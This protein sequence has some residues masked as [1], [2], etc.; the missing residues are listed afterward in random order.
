[1]NID[2]KAAGKMMGSYRRKEKI[3]QKELAKAVG[4]SNNY[5]S[6]IE[7][8]YTVPSLET[9]TELSVALGKT[10]DFFLLGHIRYDIVG[11]YGFSKVSDVIQGGKERY[12]SVYNALQVMDGVDYVMIHDGARPCVNAQMLDRLCESVMT[13]KASV[14]AVPSKDTVRLADDNGYV[15]MTPD[16]KYVWNIQTPQVF[17]MQGICSAYNRFYQERP[18]CNITDD[19]MIW[20]MY[21]SRKLRL[22][23]GD[24][25]NIKIT[26]PEDIGVAERIIMP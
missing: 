22:V 15:T 25:M 10:P 8:G 5:L 23:M 4:I 13:D 16:R 3:S 12:D 17:E 9:F 2:Y 1:M 21:D 11:K 18:D 24:Y 14:P 6:N 7:N 26:T 20:E 19:A